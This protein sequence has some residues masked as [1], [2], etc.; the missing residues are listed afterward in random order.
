MTRIYLDTRDLIIVAERQSD[1]FLKEIQKWLG[2]CRGRLVFSFSNILEC[3]I[4]LSA[5]L[6]QTVVMRTLGKLEAL[7]HMFIAEAK[8][9][10]DEILSAI[11]SFSN[12]SEYQSI[13]PYVERFDQVLS[14]F[15][16]PATSNYLKY[17]LAQAIFEIWQARPDLFT[18][19]SRH[20]QFLA[21][22][23]ESDRRRP[24]FRRHDLNF[25]LKVLRALHQ[26]NI[27]FPDEEV[28]ALA[29]WIWAHPTRCP[30]LRL[31]YEV[32]HQILRNINDTTENSDIG[33]LTHVGCI[34]YVEAITLDRR[35]R[36]YVRQAD[37]AL[38]TNY[39]S[40]I[41]A[42]LATLQAQLP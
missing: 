38:K 39:S 15:E 41:F 17:G 10:Q 2:R 27:S 34:P 42:D 23:R 9:Q 30:G 16:R 36:G 22:S 14:P 35:M 28:Q 6:G 26:F 5:T 19:D 13:T 25:R 18:V 4:P 32:Y 1:Q 7:P 3:C 29:N 8:I 21:D 31:G 11:T 12:G 20:A 33:D 37:R 24:D 40:H